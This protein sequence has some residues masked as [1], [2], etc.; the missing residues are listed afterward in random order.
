MLKS[1]NTKWIMPPQLTS[2]YIT[3]FQNILADTTPHLARSD[4]VSFH[5]NSILTLAHCVSLLSSHF[6]SPYAGHQKSHLTASCSQQPP[7]LI[8][9]CSGPTMHFESPPNYAK[10]RTVFN[11]IAP[12]PKLLKWRNSSCKGC[13]HFLWWYIV[14]DHLSFNL[15]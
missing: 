9:G 7:L 10:S 15:I 13:T 5:L 8:H 6:I 4:V 11:L 2:S 12:A 1:K 14:I 3:W